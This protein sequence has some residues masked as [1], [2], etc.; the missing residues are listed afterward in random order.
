M[1]RVLITGITGFV[2]SHLAEFLLSKEYEVYGIERPRSQNENI[3]GIR[4]RLKL[5]EADIRDAASMRRLI[6]TI[7]PDYIFH[8]AAQSFVQLSFTAPEETIVTNITGN[9]NVL[10][11]VRQL[12]LDPVIHVAG[13]S[14]EYGLVKEDEIPIKEENPLRPLSPYGVSKIAQENLS[15]QYH[16]SYGLKTV[17]TRA[18]NHTGP[19]RGEV[20]ATS[21]FAKQIAEIEKGKK[22]PVIHVGNLEAK[23]DWTDVRD[24]IKAYLLAVEK[25]DYGEPY[26]ICSGKAWKISE[27]LDTLLNLS[28]TKVETRQDPKR[29]RPS[30]VPILLGDYTKFKEKTGW[31]P[32]IPFETTLKDLLKY[33]RERVS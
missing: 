25:C 23:R 3:S 17:V 12:N 24:I 18:F 20:F 21:N 19:R 2:G 10:E 22:E 26:N 9:L 5:F 11:A 15:I 30:D 7:E 31:Q 29:L 13:S 33:W 4:D 8:L 1:K 16:R 28:G 14:E 27:M 32:E 6:K